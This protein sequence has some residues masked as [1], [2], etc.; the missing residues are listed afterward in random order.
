MQLIFVYMRFH[1][2]G[3]CFIAHKPVYEWRQQRHTHTRTQT[4]KRITIKFQELIF[5][6]SLAVS[7]LCVVFLYHFVAVSRF[8]P[9]WP[10]NRET[11]KKRV[12]TSNGKQF[13]LDKCKL[14]MQFSAQRQMDKR[15]ACRH[16]DMMSARDQTFFNAVFF[17][18]AQLMLLLHFSYM[19][20]NIYAW[21]KADGVNEFNIKYCFC[22][23]SRCVHWPYSCT[24]FFSVSLS[25]HVYVCL[26][27]YFS[28][29]HR[30]QLVLN[31]LSDSFELNLIIVVT[32]VKK[33]GFLT[34]NYHQM[35]C[36]KSEIE[37][38]QNKTTATMMTTTTTTARRQKMHS[39]MRKD[40]WNT[41]IEIHCW[42][43]WPL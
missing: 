17:L 23:S 35:E 12:S 16:V 39:N 24:T 2:Y 5:F 31:I 43:K 27:V 6:Y 42:N 20:I 37:R 8:A 1:Y 19:C 29:F 15:S 7:L 30:E 21:L 26:N 11:H 14:S 4:P 41:L 38:Q 36:R 9:L 22:C 3:V 33:S 40:C 25:M 10:A 34:Q 28:S 32:A 13:C 18:S